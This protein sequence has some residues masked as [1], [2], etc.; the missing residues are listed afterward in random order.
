MQERF[1][2]FRNSSHR[3]E[4]VVFDPTRLVPVKADFLHGG[5]GG[6][7]PML[8]VSLGVTLE[9]RKRRAHFLH[10]GLFGLSASRLWKPQGQDIVLP[11]F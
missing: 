6:A 11:D 7:L 1:S 5:S 9:Q 3:L 10:L 2:S 4:G 8:Q